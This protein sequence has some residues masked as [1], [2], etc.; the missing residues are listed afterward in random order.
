[1]LT[2]VTLQK[3]DDP[4]KDKSRSFRMGVRVHVFRQ[5]FIALPQYRRY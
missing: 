1:M 5:L 2:A 3:S 4:D